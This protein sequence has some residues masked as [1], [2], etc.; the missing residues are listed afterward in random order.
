MASTNLDPGSNT[1]SLAGVARF[2]I[3]SVIIAFACCF[4]LHVALTALGEAFVNDQFPET[5][6][7]K[8]EQL[9][10]LFPVHMLAGG[11]ALLLVPLAILARKRRTW[12]RAIGRVAAIDITI[13]GLTAY[14]VAWVAP[15]S[16]WSAAGFMAQASVWLAF[17]S[18]GVWHIKHRRRDAHLACMLLMAATASGA[19]FFRIYLALWALLGTPRYFT[20]FYSVDAWVAWLGPLAVTAYLLNRTGRL[21]HRN[22]VGMRTP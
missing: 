14:P 16:G 18:L 7:I 3:L 10:I 22:M 8:L 5:L 6:A 2:A 20:A 11:L 13:A 9:P 15:I 17:L 1:H 4:V 19:I 21:P 12:H